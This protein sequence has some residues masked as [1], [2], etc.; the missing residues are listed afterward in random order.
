ML[1]VSQYLV[2][3]YKMRSDDMWTLYELPR[4]IELYENE[5]MIYDITNWTDDD[6]CRV[7]DVLLHYAKYDGSTI[8]KIT[9]DDKTI[10]VRYI[11]P[12][13]KHIHVLTRDMGTKIT[14][15]DGKTVEDFIE[16]YLYGDN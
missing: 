16:M 6:A 12:I 10:I 3:F 13:P 9:Q 7:Y 4:I 5:Y 11:M 14:I 8:K 2:S 1:T 15:P